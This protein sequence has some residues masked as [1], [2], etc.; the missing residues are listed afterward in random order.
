[1]MGRRPFTGGWDAAERELGG[2]PAGSGAMR[3]EE[4]RGPGG[5]W[6]EGGGVRLPR[7]CNIE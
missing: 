7:R 4:E 1:V 5:A 2:S 3:R 6:R